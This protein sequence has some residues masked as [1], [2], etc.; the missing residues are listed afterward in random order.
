MPE[1]KFDMEVTDYRLSEMKNLLA[2]LYADQIGMEIKSIK[3]YPVDPNKNE[4]P[5]RSAM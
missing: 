5:K 1:Q 2:R 3:T 4:L